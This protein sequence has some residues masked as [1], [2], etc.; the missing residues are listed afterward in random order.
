MNKNTRVLMVEDNLWLPISRFVKAFQEAGLE[1][2]FADDEDGLREQA[3]AADA[4][5]IDAMLKIDPPEFNGVDAIVDMV[6]SGLIKPDVPIIFI[7]AERKQ[8][9]MRKSRFLTLHGMR[10]Y[11][12]LVKPFDIDFLILKIRKEL[13]LARQ[14][15]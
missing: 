14:G 3:P 7:S 4:L 11:T 9:A 10:R 15:A 5:V 8:V 6:T 2:V 13:K 12:W 1:I